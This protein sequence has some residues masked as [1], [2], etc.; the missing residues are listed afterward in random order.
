MNEILPEYLVK[1]F[2]DKEY[3]RVVTS[4]LEN[5]NKPN[6]ALRKY[7]SDFFSLNKG[8]DTYY[9]IFKRISTIKNG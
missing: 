2:S 3:G 8:V 6:T 1:E 5:Q 9:A 7:A 4:L